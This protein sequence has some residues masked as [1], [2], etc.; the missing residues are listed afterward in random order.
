MFLWLSQE[1]EAVLVGVVLVVLEQGHLPHHQVAPLT[2]GQQ[3]GAAGLLHHLGWA[4]RVRVSWEI[5]RWD[6]E[7]CQ[8]IRTGGRKS[9]WWS[10]VKCWYYDHGQKVMLLWEVRGERVVQSWR[11]KAVFHVG[12]SWCYWINNSASTDQTV[13]RVPVLFKENVWDVGS[14]VC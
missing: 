3:A 2:L 14:K 5:S 13:A 12:W 6:I 11:R 1:R 4:V 9:Q 7:T 8:G 10:V